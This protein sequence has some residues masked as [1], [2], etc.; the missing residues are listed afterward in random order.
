MNLTGLEVGKNTD[1]LR[2]DKQKTIQGASAN[3]SLH[4]DLNAPFHLLCRLFPFH[5]CPLT[6]DL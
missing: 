2:W 6:S 5:I 4:P 1:D 3:V